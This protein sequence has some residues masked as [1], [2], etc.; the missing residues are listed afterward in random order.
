[1]TD[2][3]YK[4]L[5]MN[6]LARLTRIE[7][8]RLSQLIDEKTPEKILDAAANITRTPVRI[9]TALL[10][11][12]PELYAT[13]AKQIP[14]GALDDQRHHVL[15]TLIQQI[16]HK[17]TI[18][19]A[20]LVEAWR[21]SPLF[22]SINKL[23]TWEHQVPESALANEFIDTILFL[24]KQNQDNEIQQLIEKARHEGLTKADQHTLQDM[25]KKRHKTVLDQ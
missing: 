1:M 7:T 4:Q 23:A 15:Q 16:A 3:P 14:E 10:L 6:E 17:P 8:H 2:G 24:T 9:A 20:T 21:D 22:E 11:Q 19:T 5:M 12:N 25:L 13:C 18:N